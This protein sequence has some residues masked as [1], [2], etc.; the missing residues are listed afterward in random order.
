MFLRRM[1]S[2]RLIKYEY[3]EN[4]KRP[5]IHLTEKGTKFFEE[6]FPR[7][8]DRVSALVKPFSRQTKKDLEALL[9][10]AQRA[11]LK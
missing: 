3:E 5:V 8:T 6:L 7:H 10:R 11:K 1:E 9:E 2:D 4:Q